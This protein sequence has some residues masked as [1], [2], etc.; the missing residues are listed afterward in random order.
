MSSQLCSDQC[1]L[2]LLV[3]WH[4]LGLFLAAHSSA[5]P[6]K[7][8][9]A[10]SKVSLDFEAVEEWSAY[11]ITLND[12]N[13]LDSMGNLVSHGLSL[14]AHSLRRQAL[15][16]TAGRACILSL[17]LSPSAFALPLN[18][19][20]SGPFIWLAPFLMALLLGAPRKL[21]CHLARNR[22]LAVVRAKQSLPPALPPV[23]PV[24]GA[25]GLSLSLSLAYL[26]Y[27]PF[28]FRETILRVCC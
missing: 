9:F 11:S 28:V 25:H 19:F 10:H 24:P 5:L 7:V 23:K 8:P 21:P 4:W 14:T 6:D 27:R 18:V 17:T 20:S 2:C 22:P 12:S 1:S 16:S 26:V 15:W 3:Y 13:C